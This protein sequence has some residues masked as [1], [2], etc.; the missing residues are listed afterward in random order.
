[1]PPTQSLEF[2]VADSAGLRLDRW[3]SDRLPDR[4]RNQIQHDLEA[5]CITVNGAAEPAR[6]K[7]RDGDRIAYQVPAPETE[8]LKPES[9]PLAIVHEDEHV[10]VIDKPAGMVVHPAPGHPGGTLA[11]A[12]LAHCGPSLAGVGGDGRWGIVHRLDAQ[13]SGLMVAA[14]TP[15]AYRRLTAALAERAVS[16]R[17][18]GIVIGSMHQ[19]G[20]SIDRPLGRRAS[21]RKKIGVAKEGQGRPS[22]TDWRVLVQDHGLAL[23]GLTL[24]TGRT[25]QIRVHL[26]S[27]GRPILSDPDYGW[28][29]PRT[30]AAI[31]PKLRPQLSAVWPGRQMLHAARLSFNHPAT[32]EP[33]LFTAMP[34]ADMLAVLDLAWPQTW[35]AP[36]DSWL[37]SA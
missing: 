18:L 15:L 6:Y 30:L 32:N 12:L 23:L 17:Y 33:L 16:R 13:T 7:V 21:D 24:H 36:V 2:T 5:G 1:M 9:I 26:E 35:R 3:L 28:T 14:R 31:A 8:R 27:I 11:N 22:Q 4:T 10:I 34:P 37:G 25:H 29:L 20:G 19:D